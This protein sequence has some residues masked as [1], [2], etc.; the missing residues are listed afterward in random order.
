MSSGD[1]CIHS[2]V[3]VSVEK[4]PCFS[5]GIS[6]TPCVAEQDCQVEEEVFCHH[7]DG[8]ASCNHYTFPCMKHN[9]NV[10]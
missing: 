2:V 9:T 3:R 10:S 7:L 5:F 8:C 6:Q 1:D 4:C